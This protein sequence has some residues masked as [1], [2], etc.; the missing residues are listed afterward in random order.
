MLIQ[1]D[2]LVPVVA[3]NTVA[4]GTS[5]YAMTYPKSSFSWYHN[6]KTNERVGESG[7]N[8]VVDGEIHVNMIINVFSSDN[9]VFIEA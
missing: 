3:V 9:V 5:L 1:W 2:D 7:L 8:E 4:H 6:E